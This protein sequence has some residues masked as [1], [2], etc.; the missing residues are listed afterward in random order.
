MNK[1][2]LPPVHEFLVQAVRTT[3]RKVKRGS[4]SINLEM[5]WELAEAAGYK[6][7]EFAT[8]VRTLLNNETLVCF[9]LSDEGPRECLITPALVPDFAFTSNK[10][11]TYRHIRVCVL[12][13]GL[14]RE[15]QRAMKG[16][17]N[18]HIKTKVDRIMDSLNKK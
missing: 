13:D 5:L 3:R 16:P 9:G 17:K 1:S 11:S 8:A 4:S 15:A 10:Y 2:S 12:E 7:D 6:K 18:Q 14:T